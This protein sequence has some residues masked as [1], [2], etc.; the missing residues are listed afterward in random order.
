LSTPRNPFPTV[1]VIIEVGEGKIVLI[2]R[3]NEPHGWAIP[4]GF[5][6]YGEPCEDAARREALEETGLQVEL[7]H[8]LGVYSAGNR[9]PRFHTIST[10]YVGRA[11][12]QPVGADDALRA[13]LFDLENLPEPIVFDHSKIL[14]D[15]ARFLAT[16][17]V[18]RPL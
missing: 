4:G 7:T 17:E 16:G 15:Y 11:G 2:E 6:D 8:L 5:V 1:D 18:P 12:G 3:L 14:A 13:E 9:D 10:V